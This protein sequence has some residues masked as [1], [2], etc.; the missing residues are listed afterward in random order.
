[1]HEAQLALDTRAGVGPRDVAGNDLCFRSGLCGE[2]GLDPLHEGC[3]GHALVGIYRDGEYPAVSRVGSRC[4]RNVEIDDR[5][6][7][8]RGSQGQLC[9]DLDGSHLTAENHFCA[10]THCQ[11]RG[12][13]GPGVQANLVCTLGCSTAHDLDGGVLGIQC[14]PEAGGAAAGDRGPIRPDQHDVP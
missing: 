2:Q 4:G 12:L 13:H 10:R 1:M 5:R 8:H 9:D 3:P 6:P 11:A 14:Y 7:G